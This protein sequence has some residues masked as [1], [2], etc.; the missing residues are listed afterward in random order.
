[1]RRLLMRPLRSSLLILAV[2]AALLLMVRASIASLHRTNGAS[3]APTLLFGQVLLVNRA[4]YGLRLPGSAIQRCWMIETCKPLSR[5]R[6]HK[7][8]PAFHDGGA[9]SSSPYR[10]SVDRDA[11]R[12]R[13][14]CQRYCV[15]V[16]PISPVLQGE[17]LVGDALGL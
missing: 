10:P 9:S 4:A 13:S 6:A 1:M 15:T 12:I 16:L 14:R 3:D 7:H 8:A 17:G 2:L 5:R 11:P